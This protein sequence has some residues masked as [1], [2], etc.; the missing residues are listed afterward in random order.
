VQ[1][2]HEGHTFEWG[3]PGYVAWA[4]KYGWRSKDKIKPQ[5]AVYKGEGGVRAD[6]DAQVASAKAAGTIGFSA[7][8]AEGSFDEP[9]QMTDLFSKAKAAGAVK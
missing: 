1:T 2:H 8:Y 9:K 5:F 3:V 6:V 7:Y 4:Q